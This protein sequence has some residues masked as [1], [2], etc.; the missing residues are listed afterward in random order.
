MRAKKENGSLSNLV[1]NAVMAYAYGMDIK[2]TKYVTGN[3]EIE[4]VQASTN[5]PRYITLAK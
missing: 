1:E 5:W 4:T 3:E 2:V